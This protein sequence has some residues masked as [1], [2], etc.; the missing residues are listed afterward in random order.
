MTCKHCEQP[1]R[2][3]AGLHAGIWEHLTG[4][5]YC[6]HDFVSIAEPQEEP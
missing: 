6:G 2:E 1:I 4:K 3:Y 5:V